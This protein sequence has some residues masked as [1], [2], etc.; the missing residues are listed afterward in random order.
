MKKLIKKLCKIDIF[1]KQINCTKLSNRKTTKLQ[2][3]E[4]KAD[5]VLEN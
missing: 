4:R 3:I 5:K 2:I 1:A